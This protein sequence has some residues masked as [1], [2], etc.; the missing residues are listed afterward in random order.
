MN[1]KFKTLT[2]QEI[3]QKKQNIESKL[4]L[5]VDSITRE[6]LIDT[7]VKLLIKQNKPSD[8]WSLGNRI[9]AYV[10][11]T[12]DARGMQQWNSVGRR[13]NKGSKAIYILAPIDVTI[14]K[15]DSK[16]N[17]VLDENGKEQKIKIL[18]FKGVPVFRYEDTN[19]QSIDYTPS[20]I[21]PLMDV[22]KKFGINV[23]YG[24][25]RLEGA[26]GYFQ[27][28]TNQIVLGTEEVGTFFHELAH[29]AH[30][31]ILKAKNKNI[32]EISKEERETVAQLS[33]CV[34]S[35]IFG[36]DL[37]DC[38]GY[39]QNYIKMYTGKSLTT[40]ARIV[41]KVYKDVQEVVELILYNQ[42]EV[43]E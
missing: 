3:E 2:V 29:V 7:M 25:T 42:E 26:Y 40:V 27:P 8:K 33:S 30:D 15:K 4:Q 1:Q 34:I 35:A 16:G 11:G 13:V 14:T 38:L 36:Y 24:D 18:R 5:V 23:S 21:P 12:L 19:G 37:T 39:T 28:A 17:P 41:Q 20:A 9:L 6:D 22:A 31:R 43:K 32:M 10:Q